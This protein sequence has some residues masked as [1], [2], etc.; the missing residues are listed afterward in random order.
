MS[1][2]KTAPGGVRRQGS[3]I[4]VLLPDELPRLNPGAAAV[5]LRIL[6]RSP[7][8]PGDGETVPAAEESRRDLAPSRAGVE[9]E[10]P[11]G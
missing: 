10:P 6:R 3:S 11:H 8:D 7:V 9:V 1:P 2:P 5:L 4:T